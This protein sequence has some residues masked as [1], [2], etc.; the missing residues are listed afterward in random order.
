VNQVVYEALKQAA[1]A[2]AVTHYSDIAPLAGVNLNTGRGR[3][4]IGCLLAEVCS[5]EAQQGRPLLGSVVVRKDSHVPGEGYFRG[6][7][8]LGRFQGG[9]DE[10]KQSFWLQELKRVHAYWATH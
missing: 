3:R 7:Q 10:D 5:S 1:R 6:A 4:E 8:R 9:S 2:G